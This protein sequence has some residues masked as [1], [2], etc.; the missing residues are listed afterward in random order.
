[1]LLDQASGLCLNV[2]YSITCLIGADFFFVLV[3]IELE[4]FRRVCLQYLDGELDVLSLVGSFVRKIRSRVEIMTRKV[5]ISNVAIK[6]ISLGCGALH[7]WH[8]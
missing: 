5:W 8:S 7:L 6:Y 2:S 3:S 4:V 1:M